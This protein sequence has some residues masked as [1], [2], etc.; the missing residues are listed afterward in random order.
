M[1]GPVYSNLLER[2]FHVW[3]RILNLQQLCQN[4]LAVRAVR[5]LKL[6]ANGSDSTAKYVRAN[7][8]T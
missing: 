1:L 3:N 5:R 2:I 7:S 4:V 8:E 6:C